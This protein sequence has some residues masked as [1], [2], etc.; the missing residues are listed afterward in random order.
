M[1]A[2]LGVFHRPAP[3]QAIHDLEKG[4]KDG[5]TT[6]KMAKMTRK[7]TAGKEKHI[8]EYIDICWKIDDFAL[9]LGSFCSSPARRLKLL[10]SD[11]DRRSSVQTLD[12]FSSSGLVC[13][14]C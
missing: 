12:S 7:G 11:K 1:L 2:V 4:K 10:P 6:K 5:K 9:C 13:S 14:F 3:A 8:E